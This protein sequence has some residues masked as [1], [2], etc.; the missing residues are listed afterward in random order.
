MCWRKCFSIR[1]RKGKTYGE[2]IVKFIIMSVLA[3]DL[4]S[5]SIPSAER[6]ALHRKKQEEDKEK[7]LGKG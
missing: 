6:K 5:S 4:L 2:E 1:L 3:V 7:I